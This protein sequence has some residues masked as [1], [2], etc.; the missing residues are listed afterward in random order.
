M[1]IG[2]RIERYLI[3]LFNLRLNNWMSAPAAGKTTPTRAT[4]V[5]PQI[6][7]IGVT[8]DEPIAPVAK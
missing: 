6:D 2:E 7:R 1:N 5:H 4:P 3:K 8:K